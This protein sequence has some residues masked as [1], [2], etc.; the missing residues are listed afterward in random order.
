VLAQDEPAD[1]KPSAR[2]GLV[3]LIATLALFCIYVLSSGPAV[4]LRESGVITRDAFFR[5]YA[6]LA[7]LYHVVPFFGT[8]LNWYARL[9]I[10]IARKM[11]VDLP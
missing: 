8:A 11:G 9:W 10:A 7:W 1:E 6:P 4:V 3:W 5:I 2:S